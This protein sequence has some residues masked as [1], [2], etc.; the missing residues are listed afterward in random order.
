MEVNPMPR[1]QRGKEMK[2]KV[3]PLVGYDAIE[4]LILAAKAACQH[5]ESKEIRYL[6]TA[7]ACAELSLKLSKK[8]TEKA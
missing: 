8:R 3:S 4:T 6:K 5:Y 1:S 7:V 2:R